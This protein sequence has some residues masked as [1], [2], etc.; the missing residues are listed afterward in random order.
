LSRDKDTQQF[1]EKIQI[2]TVLDLNPETLMPIKEK[3]SRLAIA[4]NRNYGYMELAE[5]QFDM[6]DFKYGRY[7]GQRLFLQQ[8]ESNEKYNFKSGEAYLEIGIKGTRA[9]GLVMQRR[10]LSKSKI[11]DTIKKQMQFGDEGGSPGMSPSGSPVRERPSPSLGGHEDNS[12][13]YQREID[14]LKREKS[15]L[16]AQLNAANSENYQTKNQMRNLERDLEDK[17][18]VE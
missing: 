3:N 18:D 5:V 2:N 6:A 9:D 1:D 14:A 8:V 15:E 7:N 13:Q 12:A 4:L 17:R 16:N 10:S 11:T